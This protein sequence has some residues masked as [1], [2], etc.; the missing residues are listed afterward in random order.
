M[1][2]VVLQY[3]LPLLLPTLAFLGWLALTRKAGETRAET[4]ARVHDGP[5]YWLVI[6]G[7]VLMAGGLVYLGVGQGDPPPGSVYVPPH[8]EDGRV[9]P[10][11]MK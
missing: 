2:R 11:R 7:F 6:S 9:I 4:M 1:S 3:V 10:G 5:W 8:V